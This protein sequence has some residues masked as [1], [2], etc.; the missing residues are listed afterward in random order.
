[1]ISPNRELEFHV[2]TTAM[3]TNCANVLT[4]RL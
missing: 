1:L 3:C 2:H 4:E